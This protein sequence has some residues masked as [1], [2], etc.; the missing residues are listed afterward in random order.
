MKNK[1]V[2]SNPL[3]PLHATLA[4]IFGLQ[5]THF[6]AVFGSPLHHEIDTCRRAWAGARSRSREPVD[7]P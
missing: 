4:L 3:Q 1:Y 7:G 6:A 5:S 2:D